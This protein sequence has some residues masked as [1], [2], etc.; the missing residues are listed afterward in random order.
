METFT[1]AQARQLGW[2]DSRLTRAARGGR[3]T[4]IRRD[5]YC[6][7]DQAGTDHA[8]VAVAAALAC[9]GS[10][11]SHESAAFLWGLPLVDGAPERPRLT[12]APSGTGDVAAALLHRAS[13]RSDEVITMDGVPITSPARTVLDLSRSIRLESAVAAA[14][15]ALNAQLTDLA[16]LDRALE[17]CA[18]WPGARRAR[19]VLRVVDELAESPLESLSRLAM[20]Q[21]AIPRPTL[22]APIGDAHGQF[23]ARVD[24]YWDAEGVVGEADGRL[25]YDDRD[26]IY[27]E[28]RRQERLE[29]LGLVVI[30]WGW[31]DVVR[32]P[33]GLAE[34]IRVAHE[35]GQS[36]NRAG[37]PRQW[38]LLPVL[39]GQQRGKGA[40]SR[41]R[42]GRPRASPSP[43]A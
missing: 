12:V 1:R 14:D 33:E 4:R 35:R 6:Q 28:K 21:F 11:V 18:V 7:P 19:A 36:R 23:R 34:R 16:D 40:T 27:Q 25:K 20:S 31:T 37:F 43:S 42:A 29:D 2:S 26:A 17:R 30:R 13:L 10:V 22:Q 15:A 8:A 24:F 5:R 39:D 3:V 38:S 32:R 41:A 9:R